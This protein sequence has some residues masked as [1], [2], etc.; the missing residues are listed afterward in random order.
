LAAIA[1]TGFRDHGRRLST[2]GGRCPHLAVIT[3]EAGGRYQ[4]Y[5]A[6]VTSAADAAA[7]TAAGQLAPS[8]SAASCCYQ[9]VFGVPLIYAS[10]LVLFEASETF[11]ND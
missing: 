11:Q 9:W 2:A 10:D 6:G 7:V 5:P 1:T 4:A 8:G 3:R